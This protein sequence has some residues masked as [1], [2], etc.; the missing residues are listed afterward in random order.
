MALPGPFKYDKEQ[1]QEKSAPLG[2]L[3]TIGNDKQKGGYFVS[4]LCK[5]GLKIV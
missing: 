1:S 3:L 2:H 5:I 4:P